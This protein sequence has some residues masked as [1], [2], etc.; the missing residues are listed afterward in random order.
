MSSQAV[1]DKPTAAYVLS[2]IGG[3]LGLIVGFILIIIAAM[4]ANASGGISY[5][6]PIFPAAFGGVIGAWSLITGIIV[7]ISAAKLNSNPWEHTKWGVIILVF[8][9]I[10]LGTLLGLIGG[11]LALVYEPQSPVLQQPPMQVITRICPKCGRV[12]RE[13]TKFCPYCGNELG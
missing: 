9:V 4:I 1:Q 10:G 2:L 7:I 3:I 12:L 6:G 11:I 13:E 5:Y 8:S